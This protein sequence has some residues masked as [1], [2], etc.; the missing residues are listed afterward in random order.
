MDSMLIEIYKRE[1]KGL[2]A[3]GKRKRKDTRG[4]LLVRHFGRKMGLIPSSVPSSP[5]KRMIDDFA[6]RRSLSG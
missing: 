5:F 2:D 1:E 6:V 3:S 4:S